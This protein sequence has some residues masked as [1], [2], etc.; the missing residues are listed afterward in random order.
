MAPRF[1]VP[2]TPH[3]AYLS[4]SDDSQTPH[5]VVQIESG[6]GARCDY[7]VVV[8]AEDSPTKPCRVVATLYHTTH[9]NP[10]TYP[11]DPKFQIPS[12]RLL[13]R[14]YPGDFAD[15][16]PRPTENMSFEEHENDMMAGLAKQLYREFHI[17]WRYL[18]TE[19]AMT[20]DRMWTGI[21][22][23]LNSYPLICQYA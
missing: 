22:R 16:R 23:N 18:R 20:G 19:A 10:G 3:K 5:R 15:K 2:F 14:I 17:V 9:F 7:H 21:E 12:T 1:E 8:Y 13:L 6:S 11:T 4:Q